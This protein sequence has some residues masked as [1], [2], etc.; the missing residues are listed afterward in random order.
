MGSPAIRVE[1]LGKRYAIGR[2][3]APAGSLQE[4]LSDILATPARLL[5]RALA[6]PE[7]GVEGEDYIWAVRDVSLEI[8]P[9]E[10]VAF[11]G[12]NGSGKSTML[13]LLSRITVPTKGRI[14]LRGR[15]GSLLEVGTGFHPELTGRENVFLNG[16]VLGMSRRDIA[17]RFDEI[18]A[19]SEVERFI[20]TP[21]KFYS[22]GM[23]LRL[24]FSV[25]AHLEPEVLIVDEV[26]AVG[27]ANFQR[28][29]L[30]KIQA[31]GASGRT[32]LFVSHNASTVA[33]LCN[34]AVLMN[35]GR[36]VMDGETGVVL[37]EYLNT[38]E[39]I[40]AIRSWEPEDAPGDNR[41]RIHAIRMVNES[42][43]VAESY[44]IRRPIGIQMDFS[45]LEPGHR[46]ACNHHISNGEGVLAFMTAEGHTEWGGKP[47]PV[48]DYRTTVWIP[49]NL[50]SEGNFFVKSALTELDPD[51]LVHVERMAVTFYVQ[52]T[53]EPGSVRGGR[54]GVIP[55]VVRPFLE[56]QVEV[57]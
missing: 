14:E 50:L 28:K 45:V 15:V 11:I 18:V 35:G 10:V 31:V 1:G 30:A 23:Y 21:V 20:D 49:G 24:A 56:W 32:V 7:N 43:E 41:A 16:A 51:S 33:R 34:R 38:G 48:G 8:Q 27:D 29:S 2:S 42:G 46:L 19:F 6:G 17:R 37:A 9:G 36:A 4:S 44:D 5:R 54:P 39:G 26:L 57:R 40:S 12:H 25:A 22:S 47:R 13:K 55:G 52:D 53:G 3:S